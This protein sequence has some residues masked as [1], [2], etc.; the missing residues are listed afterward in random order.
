MKHPSSSPSGVKAVLSFSWK[1]RKQF[2]AVGYSFRWLRRPRIFHFFPSPSPPSSF[3]L[4]FFLSSFFS[5]SILLS[6]L[7]S[8]H[9]SFS[10]SSLWI[11]HEREK[12]DDEFYGI[13]EWKS[14]S[15][16]FARIKG[17]SERISPVDWDYDR[18]PVGR[19]SLFLE[20]CLFRIRETIDINLYS[21]EI[22]LKSNIFDLCCSNGDSNFETEY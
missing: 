20:F 10:L 5:S 4:S 13:F 12:G 6:L 7:L 1:C 21:H 17:L 15:V 3:F 22:A 16:T 11:Y 18:R 19:R 8:P 14:G 2:F 9:L